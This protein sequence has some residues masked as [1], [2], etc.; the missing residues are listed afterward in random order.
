[1]FSLLKNLFKNSIQSEILSDIKSAKKSIKV[2]VS[3]LTDSELISALVDKLEEGVKVQVLVSAHELNIIRFELFQKI[4]LLGGE[5]QKWGSKE[6][7]EGKFMH[8]KF[9][10][11]DDNIAKS[12]SY[13]WSINAKSNAET[14][15]SVDVLKK[16]KEF[17]RYFSDSVDFFYEV[18]N[19]EK[20]KAE[21]ESI[22][23][24]K[25]EEILTPETLNAYRQV[26]EI[27]RK[28]EEELEKERAKRLFLERQEA[29]RKDADKQAQYQPKENVKETQLPP[30]SYA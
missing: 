18:S 2:A 15:D 14:L 5:V 24:E 27:Q 21:L 3:W 10:I 28:A 13:N 29:A 7:H 16:I 8:C 11:I 1:M 19:P 26:Q 17:S 6:T 25:N 9:Y 12:G 22:R 4:Q 23:K 20:E 30:T